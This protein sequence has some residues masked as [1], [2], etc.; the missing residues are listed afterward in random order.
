MEST[1][2]NTAASRRRLSFSHV[3]DET[4]CKAWLAVKENP[5]IGL[6]QGKSRFWDRVLVVYNDLMGGPTGRTPKAMSNK[7]CTLQQH[8]EIFC[9][10]LSQ[11]ERAKNCITLEGRISKAKH[12]FFGSQKCAFKWDSCWEILKDNPKWKDYQ[13]MKAHIHNSN[14]RVKITVEVDPIVFEGESSTPTTHESQPTT[15]A[16]VPI[17][18]YASP[19]SMG[20][21]LIE[22]PNGATDTDEM[23]KKCY[24]QIIHLS[25]VVEE[26][27]SL[28]KTLLSS[29]DERF[30]RSE[31][32]ARRILQL[33]EEK[34]KQRE[35]EMREKQFESEKRIMDMN[36]DQ[37]PPMQRQFYEVKQ[38]EIC[39]KLKAV[40]PN[41]GSGG[42]SGEELDCGDSPE[43]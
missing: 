13:V 32:I 2:S 36:L 23:D 37:M 19:A 10:Y 8:L 16:L 22:K 42:S 30:D 41:L 20:A 3:E 12:Y 5:N 24:D 14:K 34:T 15:Q 27:N 31:D 39:E 9:D 1:T 4:L 28:M 40:E 33:K 26:S 43:V 6:S 11:L 7:W 25:K 29:L 35:L 17:D 21:I 38:R 18:K